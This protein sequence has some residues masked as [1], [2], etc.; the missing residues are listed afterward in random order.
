MQ[1][2]C[3][4]ILIIYCVTFALFCQKIKSQGYQKSIIFDHYGP[5]QGFQ[6]SQALSIAKALNG[7]VWIGTEQGLVRYDGH[8]FK[9]YRADPLKPDALSSNYISQMAEDKHGRL[10]LATLPYL[11]IFDPKSSKAQKVDFKHSDSLQEEVK[12]YAFKYIEKNDVMWMGTNQGLLYSQGKDVKLNKEYISGLEGID[13]FNAIQ[14]DDQGIFWLSN[15]YGLHRYDPI[16]CQVKTFHRPG[17]NAELHDD[18]GFMSSYLDDLGLLWLGTWGYGL[19]RFDTH[20]Y[21]STPFTFADPKKINNGV[22][23]VSASFIPGEEDLLWL[24]TT[25]GIKTFSKKNEI[26]YSYSTEDLIDIHGVAG[27]GFCFQPTPSEGMWIGSYKGLH[28]Y[29]ANKQNIKEVP[30][31]LAK[32]VKDWRISDL[33]FESSGIKDSIVWFTIPYV[34]I[35]RFDIVN[36]KSMEIPNELKKYCAQGID[37]YTIFIDSQEVLWLSTIKY[38]LIGYDLKKHSIIIPKYEGINK[39][40]PKVIKIVEDRDGHIWLG[41]L[42]GLYL[43]NKAENLIDPVKEINTYFEKNNILPYVTKFA[44]DSKGKIWMAARFAN[45]EGETIYSFNPLNKKMVSYSSVD[46]KQLKV[47]SKIEGIESFGTNRIL[48]TAASGFCTVNTKSD[49]VSFTMFDTYNDKPLGTYKKVVID[50]NGQAWMGT[51]F[52]ITCLNP[53]NHSLTNYTYYNSSI[54]NLP[55]PDIAFSKKSNTIYIGQDQAINVI[56]LNKIKTADAG[57]LILSN[58][59][60][61]NYTVTS[62]PISGDIIHLSHHQNTL[63]LEFTNLNYTNSQENRYRYKIGTESDVWINMDGNKLIFDNIGY[64]NYTLKVEAE[65]S[66]GLKSANKFV[67]FINIAPPFWRTWW[68]NGLII[69]IISFFIYSIFKYRDIQRQKLDKL[70]HTLARDLHDDMGSTLSHIRMMSEREAMRKEANQSFKTIADKTAEIMISMTEII[71]SISPKNDSLNHIVGKIQEFAIDTLEPMDIIVHFDIID[72]PHHIKLNPEDRRHFYLIFKEAI[73][74]TAKYSKADNAYFSFKIENRK[75]ITTFRDD[76]H[77]FDPM[78]IKRGNGLKNM[79]NRALALHA[80]LNIKTDENGTYIS[81][82]L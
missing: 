69:G 11:N 5:A 26:F 71:W 29:D 52:G 53:T 31:R 16:S 30:I 6:S 76:G 19:I 27:A 38:G 45:K 13:D 75:M 15:T 50:G 34:G 66:F 81:L 23:A 74:N 82:H 42:N 24:G 77:G 59:T 54:G 20:T 32:G 7:F 39:E 61:S 70:R 12:V 62:M 72:I 79:E 65:N 37:P 44:S 60:I 3:L 73:N 67:L 14:I 57:K 35:F 64:G 41:S 10:W 22:M 46:Y 68:F 8:Q 4:H 2:K 17:E 43:Y 9:S 33:C 21:E 78:M 80:E 63:T 36:N 55:R 58:L 40:K 28:R 48:I 25:D 51:D 1:N 49:S 47:L 56:E 18:D